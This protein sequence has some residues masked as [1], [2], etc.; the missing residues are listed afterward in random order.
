MS[1]GHDVRG[2][3]Y[4]LASKGGNGKAARRPGF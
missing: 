3:K 2:E 1:P 4:L